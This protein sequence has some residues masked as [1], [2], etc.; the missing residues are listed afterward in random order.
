MRHDWSWKAVTKC[1]AV[2]LLVFGLTV[3]LAPVVRAIPIAL[4]D[5]IWQN[6]QPPGTATINNGVLITDTRTARW[7]TPVE[8]FQ[9]GYNWTNATT[10]FNVP[11]DGTAFSLG[12]FNHLNFPIT[13]TSITSIDLNF[14]MEI[15]GT[16]INGVFTFNHNETPNP[17]PDVVTIASPNLNTQF[18]FGGTLYNFSLLGFIPEGGSE[19]VTEFITAEDAENPAG[20]YGAITVVPEPATMLLLGSGLIGLAGFARRRFKK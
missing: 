12:T 7:G 3:G 18:E 20:L 13:G 17:A 14:H 19:I 4:V 10:P 1:F 8:T 16:D 2:G 11:T 15:D 9:S 5:G 6:G